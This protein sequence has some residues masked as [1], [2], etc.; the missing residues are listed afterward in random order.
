MS[1]LDDILGPGRAAW[2]PTI[3]HLSVSGC[4]M[5]D[6][7]AEQFHRRYI[8]G[9]KEPPKDY[10]VWGG[11]DH[12]AHDH[13]W[14]QKIESHEDCPVGEV[15]ERFVAAVDEIVDETG[16]EGE[17]QWQNSKKAAD[18]KDRGVKLVHAYHQQVSPRVQPVKVEE[19]FEVQ[20][21]GVP[22]PVVGRVDV[23]QEHAFIDRK[24]AARKAS[25]LDPSWLAQARVYQLALG[26]PGEFHISAK[27]KTPGVYTPVEEPGL[28]VGWSRETDRQTEAWLRRT[29]RAIGMYW[30]E[31]GPDEPWPGATSRKDNPCSWCGFRDSC[32]VRMR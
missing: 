25:S 20:V 7:C 18:V 28:A 30:Q 29:A 1:L 17:I 23:E 12:R 19:W 6:R 32:P 2:P 8:L 26:K 24:T 10:L 4:S 27:T 11:A 21:E 13:N 5:F 14:L 15:E 3:R 16:G 9:D 31:F 22:V